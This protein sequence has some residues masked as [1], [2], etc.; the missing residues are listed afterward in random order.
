[1]LTVTSVINSKTRANMNRIATVRMMIM[2]GT[3]LLSSAVRGVHHLA[4]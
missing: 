4:L 2:S 1:M 3:E